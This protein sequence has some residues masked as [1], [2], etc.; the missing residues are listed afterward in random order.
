MKHGVGRLGLATLGLSVLLLL[1]PSMMAGLEAV[2][3]STSTP[4]AF[5]DAGP[6]PSADAV[7]VSYNGID[8][9]VISLTWS[10]STDVDN[11]N[12][13]I[14]D[15][16]SA[17]GP[18]T[19]VNVVTVTDTTSEA[20]SGLSA[21]TVYYFRVIDCGLLVGCTPSANTLELTTPTTTTL[22]YTI[23]S[24]SAVSLSWTNGATYGGWVGFT[25]Y[26]IDESINGGSYSA[27]VTITSDSTQ[28]NIVNGLSLST[29]YGFLV[30]TTDNLSQVTDSNPVSFTTPSPL[31]AAA[32][33]QPATVNVDQSTTLA[34]IPAGGVAPYTYS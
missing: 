6:G 24:E 15:S 5:H 20:V 32:S 33:A 26:V 29:T 31:T 19:T 22:T 27:L 14:E 25:S 11:Y 1:A 17:N 9:T 16:S 21:G 34:C 30:R 3:G 10:R 7:T 2:P 13:T 23:T 8:P 18:W 28:T 4:A 12:Y